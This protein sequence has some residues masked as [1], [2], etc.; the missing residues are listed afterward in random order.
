[1]KIPV[2]LAVLAV[3]GLLRFRRANL[4]MWAGAWWVGIY[5]LLR[6]GFTAPIPASVV[7][8]YMG[9]VSLAIL[10][11]VSSSEERREEVS[12]PARPVHDGEAVHAAPRRD[13]RRHPGARGRERLRPDERAAP[14][15]AL[16]ANG[17]SGVAVRDHGSRQEDRSRRRREPV[18]ASRDVESGRVPQHVENGRQVFYRNCVFC[19]GDNLAGNGMFVHGLDPI[20]TNFAD[21]GTIAMLRETFLFWRISKGGPGLPE[22]GG[23]WD[24]AMPAWE[25]F[26]KED[27]IWDAILFLYDYTGQ[28]PRA[29]GGGGREM[30]AWRIGLAAVA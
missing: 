25:K 8:L 10:A 12:R 27:E 4:L 7:T 1:M 24:T 18:P 14:A 9:I 13:G 2:L 16:L 29:Q 22:E 15:A 6:F 28:R 5:V 30:T 21:T 23:P 20:P 11:Y 17:P 19:H 26:L 3:F